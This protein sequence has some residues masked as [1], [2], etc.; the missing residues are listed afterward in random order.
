MH[1][2]MGVVL[3]DQQVAG[4][5]LP[6]MG[7]AGEQKIDI[8]TLRLVDAVRVMIEENQRLPLMGAGEPC[9]EIRTVVNVISAAACEIE[10]R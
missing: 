10:F 4:K 8:C 5:I 7:M 2:A 9:G 6:A 1:E 3:P